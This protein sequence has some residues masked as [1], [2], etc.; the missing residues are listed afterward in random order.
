MESASLPPL[1]PPKIEGL[2]QAMIAFL[3]I[4]RLFLAPPVGGA[5]PS[6]L[7]P[8]KGGIQDRRLPNAFNPASIKASRTPPKNRIQAY[9]KLLGDPP[10]APPLSPKKSRLSVSVSVAQAVALARVVILP[11]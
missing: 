2:H 4:G 6:G 3:K 1:H 8:L 5:T 7:Y 9:S 10:I 11:P